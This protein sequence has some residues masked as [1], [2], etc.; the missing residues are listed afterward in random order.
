MSV[1]VVADRREDAAAEAH[2]WWSA[3]ERGPRRHQADAAAGFRGRDGRI[4]VAVA[5]GVG[6]SSAAATAARAAADH[7]VRAAVLDG[8]ADL[9]VLAARDVL[10]AAGCSLAG[11]AALT[12]AL[13]PGPG[14]VRAPWAVAWVGDCRAWS[15]DGRALHPLTHDHTVAA[16]MRAAGVVV[17]PRLEHVLTTSVRT[18]RGATEIGLTA[19]PAP[20]ALVLASD[21]VHRRLDP[22][23]LAGVV[24]HVPAPAL[25]RTL[26]DTARSAGTTD[27]ATALV[28]DTRAVAPA[29]PVPRRP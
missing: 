10:L 15:W 19:V 14:S 1:A 28:V 4:A 22:A 11:D 7:A 26:V 6:D 9:A 13:G 5:D 23:R 27:N 24:A 12:V 21:G 20:T 3:S 25:P 2:P 16:E 29:I 17:A 8:R 18:V